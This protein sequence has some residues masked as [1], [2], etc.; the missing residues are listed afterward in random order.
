MI[1]ELGQFSL[2]LALCMALVLGTL[3]IIGAFRSQAGWIAVARPTAYA[4]TAVYGMC[5]TAV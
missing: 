4:P 3:P 1:P 2:I 5:H